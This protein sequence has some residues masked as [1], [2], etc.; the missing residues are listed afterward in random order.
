MSK[1]FGPLSLQV[2]VLVMGHSS[3]LLVRPLHLNMNRIPMPEIGDSQGIV[4]VNSGRA[5]YATKRW[6][7]IL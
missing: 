1:T 2:V 7:R 6:M 5:N 4:D 3:N